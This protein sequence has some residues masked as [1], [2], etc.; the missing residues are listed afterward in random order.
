[1]RKIITPIALASLLVAGCSTT[2][3][4][5]APTETLTTAQAVAPEIHQMTDTVNLE[6]VIISDMELTQEGCEVTGGPAQDLIAFQLIATVENN[7]PEEMIEVLWPSEISFTDQD[8]FKIGNTELVGDAE[9]WCKNDIP[10]EFNRMAAGE[11]RRAAVSLTAPTGAGEM[12]YNTTLIP[13]ALPT[14]WD[15]SEELA[16]LQATSAEAPLS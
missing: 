14:T 5:P 10:R 16:K 2:E 8:G 15:I 13:G 6:G 7:T 12:I 9:I 3:T 1:M 11:K 4:E